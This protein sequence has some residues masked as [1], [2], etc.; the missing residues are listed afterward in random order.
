MWQHEYGCV[1]LPSCKWQNQAYGSSFFR[2][3]VRF[4]IRMLGTKILILKMTILTL[5]LFRG[6]LEKALEEF[7]RWDDKV[8][9]KVRVEF[10]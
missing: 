6:C 10:S 9:E 8:L 4:K 3:L 5:H 7:K 2:L 1:P